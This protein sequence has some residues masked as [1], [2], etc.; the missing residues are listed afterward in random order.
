MAKSIEVT[1]IPNVNKPK[2]VALA[3]YVRTQ[4]KS[5]KR[6]YSPK[7]TANCGFSVSS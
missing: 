4:R 1:V 3:S 2:K 6:T 7:T 5:R